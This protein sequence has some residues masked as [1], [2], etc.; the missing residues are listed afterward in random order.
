V[1]KAYVCGGEDIRGGEV[2]RTDRVRGGLG[3]GH[4][5]QRRFL[6]SCAAG[7]SEREGPLRL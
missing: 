1:E 6:L 2:A 4:P 3:S 7:S 5:G